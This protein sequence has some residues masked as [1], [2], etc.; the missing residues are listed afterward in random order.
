M[1]CLGLD[2]DYGEKK[3]DAVV[4]GSGPLGYVAGSRLF[5]GSAVPSLLPGDG[6]GLRFGHDGGSALLPV[7]VFE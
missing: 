6:D 1:C 7:A 4:G 5:C 3:R 2:C